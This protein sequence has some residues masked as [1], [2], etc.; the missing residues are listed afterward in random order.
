[1]KFIIKSEGSLLTDLNVHFHANPELYERFD[2]PENG[3][4]SELPADTKDVRFNDIFMTMYGGKLVLLEGEIQGY[5]QIFQSKYAAVDANPGLYSNLNFSWPAFSDMALHGSDPATYILG[6]IHRYD[7][8]NSRWWLTGQQ[9]TFP[10]YSGAGSYPITATSYMFDMPADGSVGGYTGGLVQGGSSFYDPTYFGNVTFDHM[11]ISQNT[12]VNRLC[13]AWEELSQLFSENMANIPGAD[14]NLFSINFCSISSDYS[15]QIPGSVLVPFP[16]CIAMYMSYDGQ[17]L[18]GNGSVV[19]G[20]IFV[21]HAADFG[22]PCPNNC[23]I[24]KWPQG[25]V[26]S[27]S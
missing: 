26:P 6:L 19:A 24:Y 3:V 21:N 13:F 20:S 9:F 11:P 7:T 8:A 10:G 14:E 25:L 16:H 17:P 1:M 5:E 23:N 2:L 4:I 12:Y 27:R 18:L 22:S 15:Q